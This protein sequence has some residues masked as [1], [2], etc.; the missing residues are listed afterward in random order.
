RN[1]VAEGVY[2]VLRHLRRY[3][4]FAE[5]GSGPANRRLAIQGLANL[6][7]ADTLAQALNDHERAWLQHIGDIDVNNLPTEIR[8]SIPD[9]LMSRLAGIEDADSLLASLNQAAPLDIRVNPF[10]AD[11]E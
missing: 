7:P 8:Y 3:R 6:L 4:H 11:R 9:S 1:E 5:S 10:K 2:D